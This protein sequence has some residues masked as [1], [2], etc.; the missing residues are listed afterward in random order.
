MLDNVWLIPLFPLIGFLINGL[1]GKKI[2][3]EAIIGGIG[4]LM[5]FLSFIVSCG[6]LMQLVG[7]PPEQRVFEKVI[8]PWIHVGNFNVDMAFL[9]DPLSAVMIM[10][11]TGVGSLIHLYS[12]GY[13]HGEEGFYRFCRAGRKTIRFLSVSPALARQ[14]LPRGLHTGSLMVISPKT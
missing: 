10:V 3:N 7:L 4:T 1:F 11:V 13:M 2:K 5:I 6:I 9:V 12:I 14:P 8:F